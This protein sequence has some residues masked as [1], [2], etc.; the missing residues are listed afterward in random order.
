MADWRPSATRD[1]L[2]ARAQ[3]LRSIR[4]FFFERDVLE[5]D[6]PVLSQTHACDPQ[7]ASFSVQTAHGQRHLVTSPEFALK[8]LLAAGS[9][10]VYQ[11]GHVFRA[12][13]AG[14]WHNPEF[15]MLE[16]YRPGI[17]YHQL[18]QEVAALLTRVSPSVTGFAS[19][20]FAQVV[21]E[22]IGINPLTAGIG[23]LRQAAVQHGWAPADNPGDEAPGAR[24][25]W[26]D[27]I[28][29]VGIGPQLGHT[30]PCFVYD[31]PAQQA[32]LT[33]IRDGSPPVAE[34]FELYWQ[35]VELAN[36]GNELTD[37]DAL[38]ARYE[39]RGHEKWGQT[40]IL[41]HEAMRNGL[42]EC[43]GVALGVDRLLALSAHHDQL[44][45]VLPFAWAGA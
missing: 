37:A 44:S 12:D 29:G 19:V 2:R 8:R 43:A 9:G 40:P 45:D 39:K 4:Q 3:L 18:M 22:A 23:E 41:L 10:P 24:A 35:G 34:R 17:D 33:R 25:Y 15:T 32:V 30:T 27:V 42:P 28:M 14:R 6:T 13:E 11:L 31:Y 1:T 16:W 38:V 26:L 7:V 36:G 21:Q 20:S 5:V